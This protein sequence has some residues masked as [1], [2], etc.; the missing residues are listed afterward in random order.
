M[1]RLKKGTI[2]TLAVL[3]A[4]MTLN[5]SAVS[6]NSVVINNQEVNSIVEPYVKDGYTLVPLRTISESLGAQVEYDKT[7]R[8]VTATRGATEV[9]VYI[10][11]Y[12]AAVNG[13]NLVLDVLPE[14]KDGTTMVPLR[15]IAT[16]FGCDV[17]YDKSTKRVTI[18]TTNSIDDAITGS[19]SVDSQVAE[20]PTTVNGVK[21][22]TTNLPDNAEHFPY[23]RED[24]PNWVYINLANAW[25]DNYWGPYNNSERPFALRK[26]LDTPAELYN[27]GAVNEEFW[28]S[29]NVTT[30][31]GI[32]YTVKESVE[33]LLKYMWN[34][35]YTNITDVNSDAITTRAGL[36]FL[37]LD[38]GYSK[39]E[40]LN[41]GANY[42]QYA[43]ENEV[44]IS[45]E[46]EPLYECA[47]TEYNGGP[48]VIELPVYVKMSFNH[49]R[50]GEHYYN[51]I[52][53]QLTNGGNNST[54]DDPQTGETWEGVVTLTMTR[55][56]KTSQWQFVISS[57]NI[58]PQLSPGVNS[59]R[60]ANT[61]V[62][63][64]DYQYN[65]AYMIKGTYA[66]KDEDLSK[67][68]EKIR[69]EF[70]TE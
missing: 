54:S 38:N 20:T 25:R 11:Q 31:K 32:K 23:I 30:G 44:Q 35:D 58:I 68:P 45:S 1:K 29:H 28:N 66:S 61:E 39:S 26:V 46:I 13:Q 5:C 42:A 63:F 21:V 33:M 47:W 51:L 18:N 34:V 7:E 50:E 43:V 55:N 10:G 27:S 17:G 41:Q 40:L 24:M 53:Y 12:R 49:I 48:N 56:P 2:V 8:K 9:V 4:T 19:S 36:F 62:P 57:F 6:A 70:R 15:F 14:I 3:C 65:Y 60:G 52:G 59:L 22:R 37:S 16:A 69:P 67:T 64:A